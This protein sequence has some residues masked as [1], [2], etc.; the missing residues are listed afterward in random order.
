MLKIDEVYPYNVSFIEDVTDYS[1]RTIQNLT[2]EI[3]K[4][5]PFFAFKK[6]NGEWRY[7]KRSL[8]VF[9][10]IDLRIVKNDAEMSKYKA[11]EL[12]YG[13]SVEFSLAIAQ[14]ER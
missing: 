1:K 14:K 5:V 3:V 12:V 13:V 8:A 9:N 2:V 7:D 6:D 10:L 11:L 4:I